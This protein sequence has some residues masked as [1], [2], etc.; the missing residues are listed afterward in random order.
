MQDFEPVQD[1]LAASRSQPI[2]KDAVRTSLVWLG[3]YTNRDIKAPYGGFNVCPLYELCEETILHPFFPPSSRNYRAVDFSG[4]KKLRTF[5]DCGICSKIYY[6][7]AGHNYQYLSF[8]LFLNVFSPLPRFPTNR[9]DWP[10]SLPVWDMLRSILGRDNQYR[11]WWL[12]W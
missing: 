3:Y 6:Y 8:N 9:A 7:S 10:K 1:F 2:L 12:D 4:T 5:P 11:T